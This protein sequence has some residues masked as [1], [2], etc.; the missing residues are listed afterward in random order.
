MKSPSEYLE[1]EIP[2]KTLEQAKEYFRAMGCTHFHMSRE[3][4][5]RY[6]E[7]LQLNIPR[8]TEF[9][10]RKERFYECYSAIKGDMDGTS[11]WNLHSQ[12]DALYEN[13]KT[14]EELMK[15]L[16]VTRNIRDKVPPYDRVIVAETINGRTVRET[17][18]GLIYNAYDSGNI[19]AAKEFAEL[20]LYFS[21][22]EGG[23]TRDYERC[24]KSAQLCKAIKVEL[25]L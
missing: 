21:T 17:R 6:D 19:A 11:L 20:S 2:I 4:P 1:F 13:L 14:N 12:M 25:G 23:K 8:E 3:F 10:W 16:E 15:I 22:Y 9:E 18:R 5:Q 24:E 7:Y